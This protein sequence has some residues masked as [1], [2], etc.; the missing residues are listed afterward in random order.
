MKMAFH[1]RSCTTVM[2]IIAELRPIF[3]NKRKHVIHSFINENNISIIALSLN[4]RIFR[5]FF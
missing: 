4:V 2:N 5:T 1:R 3:K